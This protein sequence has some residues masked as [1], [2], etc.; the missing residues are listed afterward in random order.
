MKLITGSTGLLGSEIMRIIPDSIG[1]SSKDCDL[2]ESNCAILS[3]EN[4][5]IDTVIHCAAKVGGVNANVMH[6]AEFFDDNVKMNMNV[7][8][9]CKERNIKLVS[10]LST[11]IYP[12]ATFA[13]Y[14]LTEDQVHTGP[15]HHTNAGYAYAKR[16]LEVQSRVYRQQYGC[17][18]ISVIPN[19]LYGLNDNYSLESGHVIP[20]LIRKFH[21]AMLNDESEIVIWGSGSPLRE[22][23]FAS[24][25]A[26]IILWLADNYDGPEPINIGN[27]EEISIG[28]LA[29]MI[30]DIIGFQGSIKF[31]ASKPDG[32]LRRASS[33]AKLRSLGWIE[34]Y[35][36]IEQGLITTID[37]FKK[38]YPIVRGVR[39]A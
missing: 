39:N 29:R 26:K 22:F 27:P 35:T 18:F 16:M 25:A 1:L 34:D 6:S 21:E 32:Q 8:R 19:N 10:V 2:T 17:N 28:N 38:K 37:N 5:Q 3:S 15:P 12:D 13:K 33:N 14:P 30:G 24:D 23:T 31:D 36:P 7:V 4:D 20:A 11:C 9:A